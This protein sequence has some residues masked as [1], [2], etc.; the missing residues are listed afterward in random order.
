MVE[1]QHAMNIGINLK[2]VQKE[3]EDHDDKGYTD[4][5]IQKKFDLKTIPKLDLHLE[6]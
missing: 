6:K 5:E 4:S 2:K 1:L 3:I